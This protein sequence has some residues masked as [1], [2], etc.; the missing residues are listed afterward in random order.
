MNAMRRWYADA[1]RVLADVRRG[2]W[3]TFDEADYR[4][5]RQTFKGHPA[6]GPDC[7]AVEGGWD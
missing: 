4:D 5:F 3:R 2:C 6:A 7:V 1:S